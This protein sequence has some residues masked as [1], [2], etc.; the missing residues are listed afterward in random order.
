MTAVALHLQVNA[1]PFAPP[2]WNFDF[3]KIWNLKI[4]QNQK[5]TSYDI[6]FWIYS[7]MKSKTTILGEI[8]LKEGK[9]GF[10]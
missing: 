10:S 4:N 6:W 1:P 9:M 3:S 5:S 8:G 2:F 7:I